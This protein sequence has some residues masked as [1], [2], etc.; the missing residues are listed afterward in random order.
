MPQSRT[1]IAP[2]QEQW[3]GEKLPA[4]EHNGE[5]SVL[6]PANRSSV[7]S[8]C[9][10]PALPLYVRRG[11][12]LTFHLLQHPTEDRIET[13]ACRNGNEQRRNELDLV[14]CL[15]YCCRWPEDA[16]APIH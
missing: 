10:F 11:N 2:G 3:S 8:P 6:V 15:D 9:R 5:E 16:G 12:W 7:T 1:T 13:D 4:H 14:R